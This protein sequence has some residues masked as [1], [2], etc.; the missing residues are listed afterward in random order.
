[1]WFV[2]HSTSGG[3]GVLTCTALHVTLPNYCTG[4]EVEGKGSSTFE[5]PCPLEALWQLVSQVS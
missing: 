1:M 2:A 5:L 4:M 3:V